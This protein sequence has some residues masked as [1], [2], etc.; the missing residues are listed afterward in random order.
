M[1]WGQIL[2][3]AALENPAPVV[4]RTGKLQYFYIWKWYS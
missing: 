2:L 4:D 3:S 1:W